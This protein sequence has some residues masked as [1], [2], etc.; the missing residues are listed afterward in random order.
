MI[1]RINV[2]IETDPVGD[3]MEDDDMDVNVVDIKSLPGDILKGIS[4]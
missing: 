4:V 3:P 2:I 1:L